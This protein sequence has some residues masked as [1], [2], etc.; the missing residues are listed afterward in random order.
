MET[1]TLTINDIKKELMKSKAMANMSHYCS[2][3]LYYTVKVFENLYQFPVSTVDV[4]VISE[5]IKEK[6]YVGDV[7]MGGYIEIPENKIYDMKEVENEEFFEEIMI[8]KLSADLG[9]T[10]FHA[11]VRG[12]E[13]NRW[14]GKAFERGEF[15]KID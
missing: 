1:V 15:V 2:G 3:N 10:N 6:L 9:T 5:K 11:E 4:G 8:T 13:L 14:I 7:E 12:S